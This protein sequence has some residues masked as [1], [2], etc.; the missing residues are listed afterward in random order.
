MKCPLRIANPA[1]WVRESPTEADCL[2]DEC[3]W[4]EPDNGECIMQALNRNLLD[5][6]ASLDDIQEKMPHAGQF[7][8]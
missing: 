6:R 2:E 8:R 4:W 3:A 1:E 5:V 7:T